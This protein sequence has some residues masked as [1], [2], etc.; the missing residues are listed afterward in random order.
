MRTLI[1]DDEEPA[2][3]RLRKL[4][5]DHLIIEVVGEA[6]DGVEAL[7]QI[8]KLNPD[9][10]FLDVQMPGL[11]GLEVLRSLPEGKPWPL[12]IFATAFDQ[13]ALA[14]FDAN[15]VGYLLKPIDR[16][17][18]AAAVGRAARLLDAAGGQATER[19][20][21]DALAQATKDELLS[22]VAR[23]RTRFV[24]IPVQEAF[25]FWMEDGLVKVKTVGALYRTDYSLDALEGRLPEGFFRAHRSAIVNLALVDE[26]RPTANGAFLLVLKDEAKTQIKVS[27]RQAPVLRK[28]LQL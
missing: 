1:V 23:F 18:L 17:K 14:A 2:R 11:N 15:A 4:L 8:N 19:A 22:V 20:K 9:L 7:A 25:A 10:V 26:V 21:L 3:S 16:D 5:A 27:E 24:L 13:Y 28:R 6:K 12:V